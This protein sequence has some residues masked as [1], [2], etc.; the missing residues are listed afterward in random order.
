V[1]EGVHVSLETKFASAVGDGGSTPFHACFIGLVPKFIS[2]PKIRA[3]IITV[4]QEE[5]FY[6]FVLSTTLY[7]FLSFS[8]SSF[9]MFKGETFLLCVKIHYNCGTVFENLNG[10]ELLHKSPFIAQGLPCAV[11]L[12]YY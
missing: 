4:K 12:I 7:Y 6:V 3:E 10:T 1:N 2:P 9:A 8:I 5:M 11:E